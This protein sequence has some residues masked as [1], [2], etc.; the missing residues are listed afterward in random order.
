MEE[1]TK[2]TNKKH[3]HEMCLLNVVQIKIEMLCF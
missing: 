2:E 1:K 3:E